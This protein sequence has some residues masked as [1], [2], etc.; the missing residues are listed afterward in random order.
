MINERA[1]I[2]ALSY[3]I[4]F[5]TAFIAF[6]ISQQTPHYSQHYS[7][8]NASKF[9]NVVDV[10]MAASSFQAFKNET[11]LFVAVDGDERIITAKLEGK[12]GEPGFHFDVPYYEVSPDMQYIHYCEQM[13][14]I[15]TECTSFVYVVDQHVVYPAD[16][17]GS[18]I[19]SSILDMHTHWLDD[20]RLEIGPFVSA[21]AE[22]P[23]MLVQY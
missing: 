16:F 18:G 11:G 19:V 9:S 14:E 15:P 23:W 22:K 8:A 3:V 2:V 4:G 10:E 13:S 20:G 5:V 12:E 21:S 6:G 1:I 7:D 17:D